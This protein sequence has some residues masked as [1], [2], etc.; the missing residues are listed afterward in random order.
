MSSR[1]PLRVGLV[2]AGPWAQLFHAPM[3]A[4]APEVDLVGIWARRHDQASALATAHDVTPVQELD[5]LF[6]SCEA[7]AFAVPP[8]VQGAR[9]VQA[10]EAG[11]HLLLDK[12]LGLNVAQARAVAEAAEAAGVVSQVVLTHRYRPSVRRFLAEAEGF[13]V[14]GARAAWIGGGSIPGAFF[15]TPWRMEHGALLDVGPHAL[16]LLEAVAGPILELHSAGDPTRWTELICTHQSG[17]IS[18][19]S[20][21]IVTPVDPGIARIDFY[22]PAGSIALDTAQHAEDFGAAMQTIPAEFA[23]AVASGEG[24]ALD[25]RHGLHLQELL[26][27]A[28]PQHET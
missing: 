11:C 15:A 21:S 3:L 1:P 22:G 10:A 12:P 9:A 18:Q 7:V 4:A 23:A 19:V 25:A 17:A 28:T 24:H 2:G 27:A 26:A 14:H 16:D 13:V 20:L 5:E 8:D 6:G